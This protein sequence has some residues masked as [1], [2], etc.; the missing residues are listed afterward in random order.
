MFLSFHWFHSLDVLFLFLF[1]FL[2]L[3]CCR[4]S[5]KSKAL[6]N[7]FHSIVTQLIKNISLVGNIKWLFRD[8]VVNAIV[9]F[10]PIAM[11]KCNEHVFTFHRAHISNLSLFKINRFVTYL[12]CRMFN[13]ITT[14][15]KKWSWIL[16][17]SF[18]LPPSFHSFTRFIGNWKLNKRKNV[19][20]KKFDRKFN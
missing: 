5:W 10:F 20:N 2:C 13:Q 16:Y 15:K 8:F 14:N 18:S 7:S 19:F 9:S 17:S 6:Q 1:Y 4:Y 11:A 12:A 3:S